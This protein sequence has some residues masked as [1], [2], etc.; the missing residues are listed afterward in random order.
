MGEIY[1]SQGAP[2]P[3]GD[4]ETMN[5][6]RSVS[7]PVMMRG[8][9]YKTSGGWYPQEAVTPTGL[10]VPSYDYSSITYVSSNISEIVYKVGG[11]SGTIV[12]TLDLGYDGSNN[13][14][15]VTKS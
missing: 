12:A 13:L 14:T 9:L 10:G 3:I 1:P 4:L 8:M 7:P 2:I 6:D 11:V 15:S 5:T